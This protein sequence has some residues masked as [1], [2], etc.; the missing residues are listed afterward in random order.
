MD[1]QLLLMFDALNR[2]HTLVAPSCVVRSVVAEVLTRDRDRA[3]RE[4]L[5]LTGPLVEPTP[6]L[7]TPEDI[8]RLHAHPRAFDVISEEFEKCM[9]VCGIEGRVISVL[10]YHL[11]SGWC[12]LL[13]RP[14]P[15]AHD[16]RR[17]GF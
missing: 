16:W 15:P 6:Q 13:Q 5:D 11:P 9:F 10:V 7:T 3:E 12:G 14:D 8:V 2:T 17:D 1:R 4:F